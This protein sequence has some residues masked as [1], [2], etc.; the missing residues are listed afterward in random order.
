MNTIL[1]KNKRV[2][3]KINLEV[4]IIISIVTAKMRMNVMYLVT[5]EKKMGQ[6]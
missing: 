1:N 3:V 6:N 4:V 5:K 2:V